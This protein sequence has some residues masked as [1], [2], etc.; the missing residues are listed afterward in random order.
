MAKKKPTAR[1]I[2]LDEA[3]LESL[4]LKISATSMQILTAI[5]KAQREKK[6]RKDNFK[7]I[8]IK[9]GANN[10]QGTNNNEQN[11]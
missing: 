10:E 6:E 9:K 7:V 1:T 4:V 8:S 11:G 3:E 2:T 5:A